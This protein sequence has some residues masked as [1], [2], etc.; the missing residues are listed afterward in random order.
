MGPYNNYVFLI[1]LKLVSDSL[2]P[3]TALNR[4]LWAKS[5]LNN[6]QKERNT[7]KKLI[8]WNSSG[9]LMPSCGSVSWIGLYDGNFFMRFHFFFLHLHKIHKTKITLLKNINFELWNVIKNI[10]YGLHNLKCI[11]KYISNYTILNLEYIFK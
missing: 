3:S 8:K 5:V 7:T 9:S 4:W 1:Y 11:W 2:L 10:H 6:N